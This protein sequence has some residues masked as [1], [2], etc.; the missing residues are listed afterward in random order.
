MLSPRGSTVELIG[1]YAA[2]LLLLGVLPVLSSRPHERV[3]ADGEEEQE[4]EQAHGAGRGDY[5]ELRR[6]S[7]DQTQ[8]RRVVSLV[9]LDHQGVATRVLGSNVSYLEFGPVT[10]GFDVV[11]VNR[12]YFQRL[13]LRAYL[14][15]WK[16]YFHECDYFSFSF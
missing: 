6:I 16:S 14:L 15:A 11:L 3:N 13:V 2:L 5:P 1:R 7:H 10:V 12:L 8:I 9:A 4:H